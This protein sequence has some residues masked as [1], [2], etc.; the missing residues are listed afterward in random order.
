MSATP[1][2]K[3]LLDSHQV[4]CHQQTLAPLSLI[5]THVVVVV[6]MVLRSRSLH[7]LCSGGMDLGMGFRFQIWAVFFGGWWPNL[8]VWFFFIFYF[9]FMVSI[10]MFTMGSW[11]VLYWFFVLCLV[12]I[13][14]GFWGFLLGF[15]GDF[16]GVYKR[17][18]GFW[19][20]DFYVL[21]LAFSG[22][23]QWDFG[24]VLMDS[25]IWV[26]YFRSERFESERDE[27]E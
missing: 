26:G 6:A 27:R 3:G 22:D 15:S 19:K 16:N 20:S 23:L 7:C 9:F 25:E 1:P 21:F 24:T 5:R 17:I 2:C 4:W 13:F 12:G 18:N 10:L 8:V 14:S 11:V